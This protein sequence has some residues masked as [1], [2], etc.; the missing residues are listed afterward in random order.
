MLV[1]HPIVVEK[2]CLQIKV[3]TAISCC[4]RPAAMGVKMA[5]EVK[6]DDTYL[7]RVKKLIPAEVSAAFLAI[8]SSIPLDEKYNVFVVGFFAIFVVVCVLYLRVLERVTKVAQILFISAVAFPVW[9][10]NI[11]IARLDFMQDKVFLASSLLVLVTLFIPLL[12]RE[13]QP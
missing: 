3:E 5:R 10:L 7:D 13:P 2:F 12:V 1:M 6:S 9:A 11:A 8:N 4:G